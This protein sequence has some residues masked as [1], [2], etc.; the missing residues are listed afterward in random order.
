MKS[1]RHLFARAL[2]ACLGITLSW[3]S[4]GALVA[5]TPQSK[6][7]S[8]TAHASATEPAP[9]SATVVI[10]GPL[11]SFLRMAGISQ[12]ATPEEVLPL[13]A[14]VVKTRGYSGGKPTE[15][16]VLIKRYLRQAAE[17]TA[18]A[19]SDG[20][21]RVSN[22]DQA[23]SLLA[24]LGYQLRSS[25]GPGTS[26]QTA[27]PDRAF[28]TIDSG[29]P[30][31]DLEQALREDKPFA[32]P[33]PSSPLPVIYA[34]KDWNTIA[35]GPQSSDLLDSLL[36]HQDLARL[37]SAMS[38]MDGETRAALYQSP[39]L[40]KLLSYSQVLDFYGGYLAIRSGRVVVPGG[41]G[42]EAAWRELVGASPHSPGEFIPR[43]MGRDA[44]WLA[45]Y[46]DALSTASPARQAY[47]SQP[48]RLKGFYQALRGPDPSPGATHGVYRPD[49]GLVLLATRLQLEPDGTAHLP[50]DLSVWKDVIQRN[51]DSR[52]SRRWA[53]RARRWTEPDQLIEALIALSRELVNDTSLQAYLTL[54]EID[55]ARPAG[56]RL[57]P[58]SARLL[59]EKFARYGDQYP[60]FSEFSGL[61]DGSVASFLSVAEA[62]DRIPVPSVRAN[63]IGIFQANVSLWQILA[64]QGE[65]RREDW[66]ESWHRVVSPFSRI[67]S[68]VQL[69]DAGRVSMSELWRAAT[70]RTNLT[71]DE[72]VALLAGPAQTS[73]EGRQVRSELAARIQSVLNAQRLVSLD[74]LLTLGEGLIEMSKGSAVGDTL[75][76]LA[77]ELREFEMPRP[78]FSA[79]QKF[80]FQHGHSDI[81]HTTLQTRTNLASIIKSG[82]PQELASARGRLAPF[83]RDT[84][85]GLNYAY[86][87]PPGAQMLLNSAI[88]VRSH[89]YSGRLTEET[90]PW[91]TPELINLGVTAGGGTHL[92]GSLAD[93]PYALAVVEQD[94][95]VPEHVQAL[96]W[97]DLVPSL[98]TNAVVPRWWGVT[99][100]ELHAVALYQRAGE[101]L[102]TAA[103]QNEEV[104]QRVGDI[105]SQRMPPQRSERVE[106]LLSSGQA[107]RALD[108]VM[109]AES[110]FLAHE[111]LRMFPDDI[112]YLGAPGPELSALIRLYPD[113]VSWERLSRDFGASHPALAHTYGRAFTD[114]RF[115]PTFR[116]YSSRLMAESWESNNLYWA[117]LAD[118]L[119][120]PP[121]MLNRLAP[122]LTHR[123][124]EKLFATT[125][126]DWQALSRAMRETGEEFRL[127]KIASLRL[128]GADSRP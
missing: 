48:A 54:C 46:F 121:V 116:N 69:F 13:L 55:R 99:R 91:K 75:I 126:E 100:N 76:P 109:P 111:F 86:Y 3:S 21:I 88:F 74:T 89:D 49:P 81:S 97:Q 41:P 128:T 93:L 72:V 125:L 61:N 20:V 98:L 71:Q 58:Q 2:T 119:G 101:A 106:N 19:Q 7:T 34:P 65:I 66:N 8:G 11:R 80:E 70:G 17:L 115:L 122:E 60:T 16:L 38:R 33:F 84:L 15:F 62:L 18:I 79:S 12:K 73:P 6:L 87:E 26:L 64:R 108:A 43:L 107:E 112:R 25:C 53:S 117:R 40:T 44:G 63:A 120:Y 9:A 31:A 52:R 90:H 27:D 56:E 113:E 39:G 42:A 110:F 123:M 83:L 77:A 59:A 105:L 57:T 68:S 104:R 5:A 124:I 10:P 85:V 30:L 47:F 94:F 92:A 23:K 1:L 14:D 127:G 102:L 4:A 50:G 118:E 78:I 36:L 45:A 114:G 28:L 24:I 67:V 22:C 96:I 35:A 82:T 103:A 95:I 51:A 32:L 37:F 29:F